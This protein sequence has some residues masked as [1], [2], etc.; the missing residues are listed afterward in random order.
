M[1]QIVQQLDS[2]LTSIIEAPTPSVTPGTVLISTK[3]SLISAGTERMLVGFGKAS[4]LA[5]ARQQPDRVMDV[6]G[7]VRNDGLLATLDAVRSKLGQPL[8]LGYCNVG[9]VIAVGSAVEGLKPGDRV[10]SNGPH[11]DIVRVPS[12]LCAKIPDGVGDEAAFVVVASIGLQ[13][14]RLAGPTLGESFVVTGAGLI[15]LLTVQLLRAQ[16]CR[17]LAID[18]DEAKLALARDFGAEV[19]NPARGEDPVAAGVAF[20]RG[21][22]VDGVIITASSKSNDPVTQ[23]AQMCRKRGRI[24]L[25]GVTGLTLNRAD[26]YEKELTF[27]VSCS[28]GPGRYDPA[29]EEGGQDYPLAFVRWTEKRNFEAVLDLIG[30][31]DL[32]VD[33]LVTRRFAFEQAERA[34]AELT[35]DKAGLGLI[36][37]YDSPAETRMATT[38]SFV[39]TAFTLGLP[40]LAVVGAGNYASRVLIPAFRKAGAQLDTVVTS[41]GLSG[42]IAGKRDGFAAATTDL[43]RIMDDSSINAVVIATRHDSHA[44]LVTNALEH[45]KHVFVEK[46][47]ALDRGG[48]EAVERAYFAAHANGA[49]PQLMVGFNRRFAPH[50]VKM[51]ALLA[52]VAQPKT[53]LM[54]MNAG[55]IPANHWTQDIGIGGGRIIGEACHFIDL[56]RFLASSPITSVSARRMGDAPSMEVTEDKTSITLGFADG[57]FGTIM[58]LANGSAAFPKE[59]IEVFTAGRVLQIDNFRRLNGFGWPGFRSMWQIRQ[60]KGQDAAVAAFLAAVGSREAAIPPAE[61]FEVAHAT[62]DVADILRQQ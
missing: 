50:V 40:R 62:L 48:L 39:P 4:L 34:Y 25:V 22:G 59:R 51:K 6:L 27:Q 33:A 21:R 26:F 12:N 55:A 1:K 15:G 16:G 28:Y 30:S 20:S 57:S 60:N 19:C 52:Q 18:F 38:T 2:G 44:R 49:G 32:T 47:L 45:G 31:G 24:V 43:Q 9:E 23:A 36:L 56:M 5:K 14:I 42:A 37:E 54:V 3:R 58:Y 41:G 13:G 35:E 10:V 11:A 46:P 8:P 29:Y 17:V 61:I 53:F 7:K